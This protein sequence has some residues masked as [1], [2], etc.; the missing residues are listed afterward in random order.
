MPLASTASCAP[1]LGQKQAWQGAGYP[2]LEGS[3]PQQQ[4]KENDVKKMASSAEDRCTREAGTVVIGSVRIS[5]QV[6]IMTTDLVSVF[7]NEPPHSMA[8]MGQLNL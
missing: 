1:E 7:S 5:P 6:A 3:R 8:T 4:K 2:A